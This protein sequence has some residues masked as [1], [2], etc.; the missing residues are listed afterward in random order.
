MPETHSYE[1]AVIRLVPRVER[2]EF[3]NVGVIV[4]CKRL[5]FLAMQHHLDRNCFSVLW[6]QLDYDEVEAYLQ[7][8]DKICQADPAG[9]KIAT[10][11][12]SGR[13]HWLTAARST[14]IQSSLI[15]TGLTA[16]PAQ[17]LQA[18]FEKYILRE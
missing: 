16:D 10:L 2:E 1:Y 14:I 13:F 6:P 8:W 7:S 4:Y 15:H 3:L 9:G 18:L 12:L 17:T 11:D 5:R